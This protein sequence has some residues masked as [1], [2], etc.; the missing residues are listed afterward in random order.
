MKV[1]SMPRIA[2]AVLTAAAVLLPATA[3]AQ[4]S[5][6]W[7]FG[8]SIY[9]WFPT[10]KGTTTFPAPAG[11]SDITV[12]AADIVNDLKFVMMGSFEA[13]KGRWG[14]FTDLIYMDLGNTKSQTRN[15]QLGRQQ[16]PAD[17]SGQLTLDMKSTIWT[18][19]GE[20]RAVADS[21]LQLDAFLGARMIDV[22]QTLTYALSGNVGAIA[23]PD[24]SGNRK[25]SLKNRDGIVG[26]KGRYSFGDERRWFVPFYGDIGTGGSSSTY[27]LMS[28]IGY[29][30]EWGE[31]VGQ[32][33]YLH[34]DFGSAIDTL[35]FNGPAVA[36]NFRW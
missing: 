2:A 3:G 10:L 27:Q 33:R 31:I 12:D 32:W 11:G 13:R 19:A 34:Y 6:D 5:D 15:F 9:G 4:S 20:Y 22:D 35:S 24:R 17:V 7:Q 18:L 23:L 36:F 28:G 21:D 8:A 29:A 26:V 14:G 16:V 1:H 30:F 25:V